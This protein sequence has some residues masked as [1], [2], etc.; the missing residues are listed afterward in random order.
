MPF[1]NRGS[2]DFGSDGMLYVT[3]HTVRNYL[4][5][6]FEMLEISSR[7]QVILYAM[8]RNQSISFSPAQ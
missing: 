6:I 1:W 7:A 4:H 8:S 2:V 5:C 3:K